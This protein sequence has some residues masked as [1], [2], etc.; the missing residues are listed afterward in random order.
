[1]GFLFILF[2]ELLLFLLFSFVGRFTEQ[3]GI[4]LMLCSA[5]DLLAKLQGKIQFIF[6]GFSTPG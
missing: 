3:K 5:W 2:S 1:M 4:L 6:G